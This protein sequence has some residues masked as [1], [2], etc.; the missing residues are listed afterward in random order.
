MIVVMAVM[1]AATVIVAVVMIVMAVV[2]IVSMAM[3][4]AIPMVMVMAVIAMCVIESGRD[5]ATRS[6]PAVAGLYAY[7]A[8]PASANTAHSIDLHR[9]YS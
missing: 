2:M 9:L 4:V 8:L 3:I 5:S 7:L 6:G 1:V